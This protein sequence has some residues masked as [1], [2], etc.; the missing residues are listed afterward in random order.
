MNPGKRF[1]KRFRESLSLLPGWS[2]RL[3]DGG[4][5]A[6]T[7]MPGDFL[8][9]HGGEHWLI[10]C[11]ATALASLPFKNVADAQLAELSRFERKGEEFHALVAI[12]FY[13]VDSIR[14]K[15]DC[16]LVGTDEFLAFKNATTR[17]SIHQKDA[18]TMG[19]FCDK[20]K[21]GLWKLPF[22]RR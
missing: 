13:D 17:K 1:E 9:L 12:N 14:V 15:N 5:I 16:V 8:Y 10:E 4:G 20:C 7:Q 3:Q 19:W 6:K 2:V 21:G 22:G 18:V 11:K